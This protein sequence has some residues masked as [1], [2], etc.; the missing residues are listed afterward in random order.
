MPDPLA[1]DSSK[2]AINSSRLP[3]TATI[4]PINPYIFFSSPVNALTGAQAVEAAAAPAVKIKLRRFILML[5]T[6]SVSVNAARDLRLAFYDMP[7]IYVQNNFSQME[8]PPI[9]RVCVK[10]LQ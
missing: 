4:L 2:I 10:S 5:I 8:R 7:E 9:Y 3:G 1:T 6:G